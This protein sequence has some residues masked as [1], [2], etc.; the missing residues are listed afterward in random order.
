M[1]NLEQEIKT[2]FQEQALPEDKISAM[3]A[4]AEY[5][6]PSFVGRQWP[7]L[8]AI[9]GLLLGT[10]ALCLTWFQRPDVTNLVVEEMAVQHKQDLIVEVSASR[11][12]DVQNQLPQI[13]FSVVPHDPQFQQHFSLIG[14]R[15]SSL[16]G[17][18]AT[19]L[20]VREQGT[21]VT[22]TLYVAPLSENLRQVEPGT[23]EYEGVRVKLWKDDDR[24]FGLAGEVQIPTSNSKK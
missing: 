2:Y 5:V 3:L 10:M 12:I 4:Q 11:Y 21:G 16:R 8:M 19:Q 20:K 6:R 15:Y 13:P 1:K 18:L 23:L 24:L 7:V 22:F 9:T 14:A 17:N